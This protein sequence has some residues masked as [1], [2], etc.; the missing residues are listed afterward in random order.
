MDQHHYSAVVEWSAED[1]EF[2]AFCPEFP[3]AS[4]SG[5]TVMSAITELGESIEVLLEAYETK[6]IPI[7]EPRLRAAVNGR[8]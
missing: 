1:E 6:R 2:V 4:G 5:E 7:P 3:N 8:H